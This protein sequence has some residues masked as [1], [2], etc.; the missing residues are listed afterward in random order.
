[1]PL[2][3][4]FER[5]GIWLF[6]WRSYLPIATV[7]LLLGSLNQFNYPNGSHALDRAWEVFCILLSFAGLGVRVLTAGFA[8]KGTSERN[9]RRHL[10][11]RLNTT[12]MYSLVRH[13]L[14]LGNF[15]IALGVFSFM[16]VWWLI[17]IYAL[18]FAL[19]YERIMFAEEKFLREKFGEEYLAWATRTPAFLPRRW[20]WQAPDLTFSWKAVLRREY[21]TPLYIV[22]VMFL[23]ELATDFRVER[24]FVMDLLWISLLL[25]SFGLFA[26]VRVLQKKTCFLEVEGH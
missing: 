23:L 9:S 21:R 26:V 17:V 15:L 20:R 8:P 5:S 11:E 10:A 4:E 24:R 7:A 3:E 6:R 12:G 22:A 18:V 2:A 14:Y 1:M 13:P 25:I 19:Y 16:R